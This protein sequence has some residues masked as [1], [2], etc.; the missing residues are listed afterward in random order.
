M[1]P[2]YCGHLGKVS[3]IERCPHLRGICFLSSFKGYV[4]VKKA[5]LGFGKV[6]EVSLF[7]GCPLGGVPLYLHCDLK[8]I[9]GEIRLVLLLNN[10]QPSSCEYP[11][12]GGHAPVLGTNTQKT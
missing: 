12:K 3:Y 4:S 8:H 9:C 2:L 6:T 5:Y 1:E 7:Q 11:L 10:S